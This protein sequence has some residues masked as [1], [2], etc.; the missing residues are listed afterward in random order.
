MQ[1]K[2]L[3]LSRF[4]EDNC[5]HFLELNTIYRELRDLELKQ[6]LDNRIDYWR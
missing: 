1:W 5:M 3:D 2:L 4:N 6:D